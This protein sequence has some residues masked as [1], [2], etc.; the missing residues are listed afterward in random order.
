MK[1]ASEAALS[2]LHNLLC[3]VMKQ[4]LKITDEEGRV[5]AAVLGHVARFL[6]D[7]G[8]EAAAEYSKELQELSEEFPFDDNVV[9]FGTK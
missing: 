4:Q 7:N 3:S 1:S 6:K 8:I 2:E 9:K 5:N